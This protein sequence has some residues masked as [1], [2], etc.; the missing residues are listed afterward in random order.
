MVIWIYGRPGSGK[1]TIANELYNRID[2]PS[3]KLW[4]ESTFREQ[5]NNY[6]FDEEF[7]RKFTMTIGE[8]ITQET[9]IEF[10]IVA[11]NT[12]Y[13]DLRKELKEHVSYYYEHMYFEIYCKC[14]LEIAEA[15][16]VSGMYAKARNGE[17]ENFPGIDSRFE[18]PSKSKITIDTS[19]QNIQQNINN[20]IKYFNKQSP[21]FK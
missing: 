20:I 18:E 8:Q 12:P 9:N 16:D 2:N 6:K 4:D 7:V 10:H 19:S 11:M 13:Q 1:T 15:R 17:I 3:K 14:P 5:Y 21:I